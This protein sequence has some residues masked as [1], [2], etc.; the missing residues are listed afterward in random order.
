[1]TWK[2]QTFAPPTDLIDTDSLE[3][4]LAG[5]EPATL[6]RLMIVV[7]IHDLSNTHASKI[8]EVLTI[9]PVETG[10]RVSIVNATTAEVEWQFSNHEL[11]F[12]DATYLMYKAKDE[13]TYLETPLLHRSINHYLLEHLSP[14]TEYE[15][16]L[17][18]KDIIGQTGIL[19]LNNNSVSIH[20][21]LHNLCVYECK[22]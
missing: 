3:F 11:Q 18:A 17:N 4:E 9:T 1:M 12:I 8:Y 20:L 21:R 19:I 15:V 10:L 22:M 5:L 14:N 2:T 13:K 16:I 6:Y 7:R